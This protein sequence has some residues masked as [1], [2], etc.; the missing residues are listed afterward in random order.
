[1]ENLSG[2]G[3]IAGETTRAYRDIFTVSFVTGRTVGIGAYLVRLGQRCVYQ[4]PSFAFHPPR[5][6]PVLTAQ[7]CRRRRCIQ[8]RDEPI[9]LTGAPAL[10]K[11]LGRNVYQSN[12]EIG[13]TRIMYSNGI[14]HLVVSDDLKG[15]SEFL[16]WLAYVPRTSSSPLPLL[17]SLD[18][19]ARPV[20][21]ERFC[22]QWDLPE[23]ASDPLSPCLLRLSADCRVAAAR[24]L[25]GSAL[26]AGW[27]HAGWPLA[28]WLLRPWLLPRV[29]GW[30]GAQ[31]DWWPRTSRRHPCGCDCG[32]DASDR[33]GE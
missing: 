30:L 24:R 17:P 33:V 31:R 11:V 14:S 19:V 29:P 1:M 3:L 12:V 23:S 2:S 27:R 4:S 25:G 18:S 7:C 15:V 32:G 16:A 6:A 13:G 9:L 20:S 28:G 22:M 8:K 21:G 5:A 26:L 10:N